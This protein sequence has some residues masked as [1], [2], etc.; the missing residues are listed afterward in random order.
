[1]LRLHVN[2]NSTECIME[3]IPLGSSRNVFSHSYFDSPYWQ[4][5]PSLAPQIAAILK[6]QVYPEAYVFYVC[7]DVDSNCG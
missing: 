6:L 2:K 3:G 5:D 1:M 7:Q 4:S